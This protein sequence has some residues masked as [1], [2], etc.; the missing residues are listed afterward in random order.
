MRELFDLACHDILLFR[1]V[2][3]SGCEDLNLGPPGSE[4]GTLNRT[5]LHPEE[6]ITFDAISIGA[7][8]VVPFADRYRRLHPEQQKTPPS[9]PPVAELGGVPTGPCARRYIATTPSKLFDA[10]ST[11]PQNGR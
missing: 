9:G 7:G 3:W 2:R 10:I 4:P 11:A 5:E 8:K 6:A 1:S